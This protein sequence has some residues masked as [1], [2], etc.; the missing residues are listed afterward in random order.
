MIARGGAAADVFI[1]EDVGESFFGGVSAKQFASDL[2]GIGSIETIN[3]HINSPG[4]QVFEGLAIYR[5]LVDHPARVVTHV[6]GLAASIASVI[7]MAG[8]EIR[9]AEAG[10]M[11]IHNAS[12]IGIGDASEM[13]RL[14]DLL[15]TTTGSIA[16]VYA[17]RTGLGRDDLLTMMN[18]ETWLSAPEAVDKGFA[19]EAVANLKVTAHAVDSEKHGFRHLPQSLLKKPLLD[20]AKERISLMRAK[21]TSTQLRA[22]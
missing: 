10:F 12:A 22:A 21:I 2:K 9:I 16:D 8:N 4:G 17:A 11:M 20:A 3:L 19:N 1:Y 5:Q 13:R 18:A 6:D 7:A 15:D 14:A